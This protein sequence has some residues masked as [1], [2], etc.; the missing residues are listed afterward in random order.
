MYRLVIAALLVI[1][2][3][4]HSED[5][6]YPAEY[7]LLLN[8]NS[9]LFEF[10][11][12][13]PCGARVDLRSTQLAHKLDMFDVDWVVELS[14]ENAIINKWPV[15]LGAKP[16]A[17]DEDKLYLKIYDEN[18]PIVS[19]YPDGNISPDKLASKPDLTS[20]DC[21]EVKENKDISKYFYCVKMRDFKGGGTRT[22][23]AAP[24]CS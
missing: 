24:V 5:D 10:A 20:E 17:V 6:R 23:A 16:L 1:S 21:P 15:P 3:L 11:Y 12:P 19:I 22:L 8:R 7:S 18:N 14:D 13:H 9:D 4:A 2:N